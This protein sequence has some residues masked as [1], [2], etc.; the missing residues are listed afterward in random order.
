MGVDFAS[1]LEYLGL[2]GLGLF[3][4][5]RESSLAR[6]IDLLV[7]KRLVSTDCPVRLKISIGRRVTICSELERSLSATEVF[8]EPFFRSGNVLRGEGVSGLSPFDNHVGT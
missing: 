8:Q 5:V 7:I 6:A 1:R 2:Y 4:I 3:Q